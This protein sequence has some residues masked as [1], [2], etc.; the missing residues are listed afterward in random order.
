VIDKIKFLVEVIG[1]QRRVWFPLPQIVA[2]LINP[3]A[4][5]EHVVLLASRLPLICATHQV[6]FAVA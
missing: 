5:P 2:L 1:A 3:A 4:D 6:R